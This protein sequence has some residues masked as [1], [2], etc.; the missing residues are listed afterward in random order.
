LRQRPRL[1]DGHPLAR[2]L[3]IAETALLDLISLEQFGYGRFSYYALRPY[4]IDPYSGIWIEGPNLL[5]FRQPINSTEQATAY[6]SRLNSLSA[7]LQDTKR[8][9][10]ADRAAGIY[11]PRQLAEE[12]QARLRLLIQDDAMALDEIA[13]SFNALTLDVGDLDPA[14]RDRMV[15]LVR[16]Q[17]DEKLEPAYLSLIETLAET[18]DEFPDQAGIAAQPNGADL[19]AG[20]LQASTGTRLAIETLHAR[21]LADVDAR[22]DALA[23][24]LT[25]PEDAE[26]EP[27]PDAFSARLV[28]FAAQQTDAI[29]ASDSEIDPQPD[30]NRLN[31]LSPQS[32][33]AQIAITPDYKS[34][35]EIIGRFQ[36][37]ATSQALAT[38]VQ[39]GAGDRAALRAL[40]E[41]PSIMQAWHLYVWENSPAILSESAT[42]MDRIARDQIGLVQHSLAAADT[43]LHLEGW[44]LSDAANYIATNTGLSELQSLDLALQIVARPGHHT[45]IVA[46]LHRFE[47]LSERAQAILGEQYSETDFL[48]ALI[49]PGLRP[50]PLIEQDIEAWYGA[51]LPN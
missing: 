51:K 27:A 50:L 45:A 44:S 40:I 4:A 31:D 33:W 24:M 30:L 5:A 48:R 12:T 13:R 34:Q 21:H 15:R 41:Y 3:A 20:I 6:L 17:I 28:W 32:I 23:A 1:P 9:L 8:R 29:A 43:G 14:D 46:A 19:F 37:V 42:L 25:G 39:A 11:L 36:A 35:A 47:A 26:L 18:S 16:S 22:R 49:Q 7:A 2:D 10:I 38:S